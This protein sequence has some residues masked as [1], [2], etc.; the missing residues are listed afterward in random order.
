MVNV[1]SY[2]ITCA[3]TRDRAPRIT[4]FFRYAGFQYHLVDRYDPGK[5]PKHIYCPALW[6][7]HFQE[8]RDICESN[9]VSLGCQGLQAQ[10]YTDEL[11]V[12]RTL[13]VSELS[14]ATKILWALNHGLQEGCDY[15]LVAEDDFRALPSVSMTHSLAM[16]KDIVA[17]LVYLNGDFLDIGGLPGLHARN[18]KYKL[19]QATDDSLFTQMKL[20]LTRSTCCFV[21]SRRLASLILR[22]PFP[23]AMPI[24]FHL[25]YLY[26]KAWMDGNSISAYWMDGDI[27]C[28]GSMLGLNHTSIQK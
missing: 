6:A 26:L 7:E 19:L 10:R 24:D 25:Q 11:A 15:I 1:S 14:L 16:F 17:R 2:I 20:P 18:H 13:K 9:L 27:F 12:G 23:L 21:V 8:I 28:N 3:K 22:S 5:L 4:G